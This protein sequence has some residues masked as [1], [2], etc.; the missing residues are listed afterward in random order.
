MRGCGVRSSIACTAPP[1]SI[2]RWPAPLVAMVVPADP[3]ALIS[4]L[5]EV[6]PRPG[7]EERAVAR[8]RAARD[9][10]S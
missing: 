6:E 7:W 10:G 1:A 2:G 4:D 8:W 5:D 9:A 3:E